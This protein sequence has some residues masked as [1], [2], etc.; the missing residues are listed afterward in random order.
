M[1]KILG[2]NFLILIILIL[3]L[4]LIL[5]IFNLSQIM[6]VDRNL[7][8]KDKDNFRLKKNS[9]GEIFGEKVYTDDNG[10][11][12]PN[13]NFKYSLDKPSIFFIG[14]S[15]TLGNG[16]KEEKTFVGKLR[17]KKNDFD[18]Y[19]SSVIGYQ[20]FHHEKNLNLINEFP[21]IA[22]IFYVFTLNDVFQVEQVKGIVEENNE[23]KKRDFVNK[24]KSFKLINSINVFFRNKSHIYM[25]FKGLASDPSKRYFKY[26]KEYYNDKNNYNVEKN[27]LLKLKKISQNKNINLNVLILPYEFQTRKNECNIKNL[28]PQKKIKGLLKSLEINYIEFTDLFCKQKNPKNLF[29]KYDPMHLSEEG[30]DLVF[31]ILEKKV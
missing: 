7:I 3:S 2:I 6:G 21:K 18:V 31:N 8:V 28:K 25:L 23:Q 13:K 5:N 20:F 9:I 14:D 22:K 17:I 27:Y 4:E 15:T 10:F 19:N 29:L 16:I 11:R 1:K 24:I 30:H 12:V 26:V